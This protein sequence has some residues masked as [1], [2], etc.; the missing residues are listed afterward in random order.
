MFSGAG[1]GTSR[2]GRAWMRTGLG[3]RGT[4]A[5]GN[6]VKAVVEDVIYLGNERSYTLVTAGGHKLVGRHQVGVSGDAPLVGTKVLATWQ[7]EDSIVVP[8]G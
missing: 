3:R 8:V 5:G 6:A 1:S 7:V 4:D 2:S